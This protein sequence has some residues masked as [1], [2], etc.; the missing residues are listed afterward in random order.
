M[1]K[2]DHLW[3]SEHVV[4]AL[5]HLGV[6][7]FIPVS[8]TDIVEEVGDPPVVTLGVILDY[9]CATPVCCPEAA[10]NVPFLRTQGL[11]ALPEAIQDALILFDRPLVVV[12]VH[13][14]YEPGYRHV[15][16]SW[17]VSDCVVTYSSAEGE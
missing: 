2:I 15:S 1:R 7:P 14:R 8:I 10:C 9:R 13:Q 6:H 5:S 17:P 16:L 11:R 12:R 4:A 3:R